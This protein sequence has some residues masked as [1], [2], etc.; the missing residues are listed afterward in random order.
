MTQ[1]PLDFDPSSLVIAPSRYPQSRETS[2]L[3]AV[4]NHPKRSGQNARVLEVITAAG[5]AGL[6]DPEIARVTGLQRQT[7]C[8]RRHDLR[9]LLEPA[10]RRY[11][12]FGRWC[13]CWKVKT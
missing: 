5:E 13:Q 11:K 6:S 4:A 8:V 12:H 2:A 7:I 10:T 9:S 3:A 1:F